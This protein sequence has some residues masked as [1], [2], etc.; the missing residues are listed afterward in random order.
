MSHGIRAE[1]RI[2]SPAECPIARASESTDGS[3]Y[4]ISKSV[5]PNA[6]RRVTEEFMLDAEADLEDAGLEEELTNVFSY[7][8]KEVYRF[9]RT[10]GRGCPCERIEA[11]DCPVVDVH[12]HDG[13][14]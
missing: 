5:D 12:T 6:P 10:M 11:F 1:V 2:D 7:G 9:H 14:L 8:S 3:T 13:S 4:S